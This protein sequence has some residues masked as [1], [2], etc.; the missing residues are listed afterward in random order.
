ME[1]WVNAQIAV[2]G[3]RDVKIKAGVAGADPH[4][5]IQMLFDGLLERIAQIKGAIE[6]NNIELKHKK[7]N[8]AIGI[9]LGL[10][11]SLNM[12]QADDIAG[13]LDN[14]YD[15]VQRQIWVA[16]V[17]SDSTLL[18]ECTALILEISEAWG[19]ITFKHSM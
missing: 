6:Q 19:Q 7:V 10:R 3:Y 5:L 12:E 15:Y 4:Q 8:Q 9:I 11:E 13:G 18:D 2:K 17:R 14:L 1:S 16:H